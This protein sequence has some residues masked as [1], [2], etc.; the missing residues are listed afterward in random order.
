MWSDGRALVASGS[1]FAPVDFGG[2]RFRIGQC[3][4]SFI[5]P[6]VGLGAWSGRLRRITDAMFL[7][8]ARV[9]AECVSESELA[10]GSLFPRLNRIR[11][12]SHS[13]A[14]A[15]IRR[16]MAQGHADSTFAQGLEERV[17]RT[18]WFPQYLPFRAE[19]G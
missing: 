5:F 2:R 15:V 14:C 3:N 10:E 19:P 7:D 16:A 13:I 6:G 8:A 18:M 17:R 11:D 4:N 12:I 1:P 9:L